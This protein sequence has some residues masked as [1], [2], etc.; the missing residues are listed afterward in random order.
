LVHTAVLVTSSA[1]ASAWMS[2]F[3]PGSA[4]SFGARPSSSAHEENNPSES[5]RATL[6]SPANTLT[7]DKKRFGPRMR[8][9]DAITMYAI[10]PPRTVVHRARCLSELLPGF[11]Q[12]SLIRR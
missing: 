7:S 8:N 5:P 2:S 10:R 3:T 4:P 1:P 12:W 6:V 9:L 11:A